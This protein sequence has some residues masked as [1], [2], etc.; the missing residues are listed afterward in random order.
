[1]NSTKRLG[2]RVEWKSNGSAMEVVKGLS[3]LGLIFR[4]WLLGED[5]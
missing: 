1:M 3:G 5:G 4:T 2:L